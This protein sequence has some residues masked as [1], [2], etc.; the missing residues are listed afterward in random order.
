ML[1]GHH[2]TRDLFEHSVHVADIAVRTVAAARIGNPV[3]QCI[4]VRVT[5]LIL[6]ELCHTFDFGRIYECALQARDFTVKRDEHVPLSDELICAGLVENGARVDNTCDAEGY[7]RRKIS[8]NEAGNNLY[9]RTLSRYD[10]VDSRCARKLSKTGD[11]LFDLL[12]GSHDHVGKLV[13]NNHYIRQISVAFIGIETAVYEFFVVLADLFDFGLAQQ[14]VTRLHFAAQRIE[15]VDNFLGIG[16]YRILLAFHFGEEMLFEARE[17]RQ[18]H[19]LG[20]DHHELHL[21]RMFFVQQRRYYHVESHTLALSG[22]SCYEQVGHL[23]KVDQ[24]RLVLNGF[25]QHQRQLG[26]AVLK[27]DRFDERIHGNDFAILVR[28]FD[29]YGSL[30]GHGSDNSYAQCL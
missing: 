24:K 29:A 28:D 4:C 10:Q 12:A 5:A 26:G 11:R 13:D 14:F 15:R 6:D 9:I 22:G 17:K 3:G 30:A 16:K 7:T 19:L 2:E 23:C 25:T 21:R 18:F 20:V 27:P 1:V 8:L